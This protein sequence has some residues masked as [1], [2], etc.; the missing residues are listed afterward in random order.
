MRFVLMETAGLEELVPEL[1]DADPDRRREIFVDV[2]DRWTRILAGFDV[3][4]PRGAVCG[5]HGILC[6]RDAP[7]REHGANRGRMFY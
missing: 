2:A 1:V 3:H 7:A 4:R 5:G 6:A